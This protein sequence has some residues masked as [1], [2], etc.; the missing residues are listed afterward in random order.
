MAESVPPQGEKYE[1]L[2]HLMR[3]LELHT[4]YSRQKICVKVCKPLLRNVK[5]SFKEGKVK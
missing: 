5:Q 2:K 4:V 1:H 3:S